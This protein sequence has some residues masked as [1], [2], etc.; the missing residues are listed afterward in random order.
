MKKLN[1]LFLV[2]MLIVSIF[3]TSFATEKEDD[4]MYLYT[5]ESGEL[6]QTDELDLEELGNIQEVEDYENIQPDDSSEYLEGQEE[7]K[8]GFEE[9]KL[10]MSEKPVHSNE[11]TEKLVITEVLSDIKK[12]YQ[13]DY[14]YY[15]EVIYQLAKVKTGEGKI[16][17]TVVILNSDMVENNHI[18]PLKAG[19]SIY[20]YVEIYNSGSEEYNMLEHDFTDSEIAY[21]SY[22]EQDRSFGIILLAI[23]TILVLVLY[24]GKTGAKALIPIFVALDLLFIVF[25]PMVEIGKSILF[26][27]ILISIELIILITVLK[28]G[29][30][31]KTLV[32]IISSIIVVVVVASLA[33]FF[34]YTNRITGKNILYHDIQSS[35]YYMEQLLKG[36]INIPALFTSFI[37]IIA[38]VI[39]ST[40]ASKLT[41]LS[42][43]YAG[44]K[45]MVN[46][47]IEEAKAIICEYPM[48][49]TILFL[50]MILPKYMLIVFN[51]A[52]AL[53]ILTSE[54]LITELSVL[55]LTLI[56]SVIISP[57]HAIVSYLL[58]GDVEIKQLE[59]KKEDK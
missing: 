25:V 53:E 20:G 12:S 57:I 16:I 39:T 14:Y 6:V 52:T 56:S 27:S 35:V 59:G 33:G 18:Q 58:M 15:Y 3:S 13:T 10:Y 32:A 8:T 46:N 54:T 36:E 30:T 21:V 24:A 51:G 26:M 4:T 19:D 31:R 34:A 40:I 47:I 49:I 29:L 44:S 1:L 22:M 37:I 55:L 42:E 17:P 9:Q 2:I 50:V 11:G 23:L 45:D 38:S 5:D 7:L 28:N 48:I 41:E 43:K